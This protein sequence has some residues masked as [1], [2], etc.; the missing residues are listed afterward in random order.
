MSTVGQIERRTQERVV[1]L[2]REQLDLCAVKLEPWLGCDL[3][4]VMLPAHGLTSAPRPRQ[5][6]AAR[7]MLDGGEA[8]FPAAR[9]GHEAA[10]RL[11]RQAGN[12]AQLAFLLLLERYW[13]ASHS[14]LSMAQSFGSSPSAAPAPPS[15]GTAFSCPALT[16]DFS[17]CVAPM[18][19]R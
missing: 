9:R 15:L 11:H 19:R 12:R 14:G 3:R 4:E 17:A 13:H 7:A 10:R 2:F 18:E 1:T 5:E 6:P 16:V 8:L